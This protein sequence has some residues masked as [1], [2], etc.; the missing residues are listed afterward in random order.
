MTVD[1]AGSF[2]GPRGLFTGPGALLFGLV[3]ADLYEEVATRP[4]PSSAVFLFFST[5]NWS[6]GIGGNLWLST[7]SGKVLQGR[8]LPLQVPSSLA[9][10]VAVES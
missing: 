4:R 10:A 7:Y 9:N 3:G 8:A 2:G 1:R 5:I 6:A